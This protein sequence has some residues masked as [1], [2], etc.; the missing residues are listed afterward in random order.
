MKSEPDKVSYGEHANT[1]ESSRH[2]KALKIGATLALLA[3]AAISAAL[4]IYHD[5]SSVFEAARRIRWG[6]SLTIAI[7]FLGTALHSF[8]WRML[9]RAAR[10]G[11]AKLLFIVRWIRDSLNY[12]L[13]SAILGGDI[14]GVRLLVKRGHDLNTTSAIIVVDKTLE[15]AGL[16]FFG[17]AG[18]IT[19]LGQGGHYNLAL[20]GLSV[21]AAMVTALFVAQRWGL[22]RVLGQGGIEARREMWRDINK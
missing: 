15:A 16:F 17:L 18:T 9:F 12:L 13:P 2:E 4:I 19:L 6:L 11:L 10:S 1:C 3:G 14:V 8:A 22:L 5:F 21:V 7:S 20:L